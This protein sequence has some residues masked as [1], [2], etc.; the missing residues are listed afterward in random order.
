MHSLSKALCYSAFFTS[1]AHAAIVDDDDR[2]D[3]AIQLSGGLLTPTFKLYQRYDGNVAS[4]DVEEVDSWMTIYQPHL[5]YTREFGEFGKHNIQ[6]DYILAHGAY[7]ASDEDTYTDH[8]ISG[9]LNYEINNRHRVQVEAG[10]IDGH[11]ERG[12]RFSI[13]NGNE[14][15]EPDTYEQLYANLTYKFGVID[16]DV[17]FNLEYGFLDNAYDSRYITDADGNR[18]DRTKERDRASDQLSGTVF[19]KIGAVT[20]LTIEA[21]RLNVDYDYTALPQNELSS[22]ENQ[23]MLGVR[24]EATALTTG[25]AKIGYKEKRFDLSSREDHT[26]FEWDVSV[27]WEPKTY[28]YFKLATGRSTQETNGEGFFIPGQSGLGYYVINTNYS[29]AWVH[30]WNNRLSTQLSYDIDENVYQGDIGKL[31]TDDNDGFVATAYYDMNYWLS[32]TLEYVNNRRDSTR[33]NLDYDRDLV[34]LGVRIALK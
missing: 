24:W 5:S 14:L 11:D 18:I 9:N 6:L 30:D 21:R 29:L 31:R 2:Q 19:Y 34:T 33:N 4:S 1:L 25:Y 16:A 3:K 23:Y 20:D 8:D 32:F 26:G 28:S 10:Y 17:R 15:T 22:I 7:H 27:K 13:G 12:S